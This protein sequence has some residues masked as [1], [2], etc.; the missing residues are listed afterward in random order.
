MRKVVQDFFKTQDLRL[1]V[2]EKLTGLKQGKRPNRGKAFR[3]TL[4]NWNYRELLNAIEMRCEENR[5]SFRSINPSK[6]SQTCPACSHTERGN[7]VAE[8]FQCLRCGYSNQADIVGSLNILTR[9]TSGQYG[10]AFQT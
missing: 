9:F 6:T 1:V 7:R 8:K 5:V 10:A 3:K 2:V 4:S